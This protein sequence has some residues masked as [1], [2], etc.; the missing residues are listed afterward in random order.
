[1]IILSK[2]H[3]SEIQQ[4][5]L[6]AFPFECCGAVIG[7]VS[8]DRKHV[9]ELIRLDNQSTENQRRRFMVTDADYQYVET[10]AKEKKLT[11]L[12]FYHSHPN[13]PAQPSETDLKY[14]WPFF[15]YL[16]QSVYDTTIK[17]LH[18]FVL[19]LDTQQ[20]KEEDV[21]VSD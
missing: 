8:D 1:M 17:D 11:L 12:G 7:D 2:I 3:S 4:H 15:S 10:V 14:A 18:S 21:K 5:S 6:E 19:D 16:I 9:K 20:F 13:H